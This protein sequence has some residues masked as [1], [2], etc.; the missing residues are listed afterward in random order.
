MGDNDSC[1]Q[2]SSGS[3]IPGQWSI[4]SCSSD[5]VE[6]SN[7]EA[8]TYIHRDKLCF[9]PDIGNVPRGMLWLNPDSHL[10]PTS[11]YNEVNVPVQC[12]HRSLYRQ[13]ADGL[14]L[15]PLFGVAI[16]VCSY[17][18]NY[19]PLSARSDGYGGVEPEGT[20]RY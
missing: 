16:A 4:P 20:I 9:H 14:S 1:S 11:A 18:R 10:R 19:L 13:A 15:L 5:D 8:N 3:G 12:G 7:S 17:T 6:V 2:T